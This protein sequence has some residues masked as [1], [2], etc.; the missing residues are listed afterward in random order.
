MP[1][2]GLYRVK[3]HARVRHYDPPPEPL[4]FDDAPR[5]DGARWA[6]PLG[7]FRTIT[8]SPTSVIAV[9]RSIDNY[10]TWRPKPTLTAPKGSGIIDWIKGTMVAAPDNPDEQLPVPGAVPTT[11]FEDATGLR[12]PHAGVPRF[13]DLDHRQTRE[14]LT[15]DGILERL[16]GIG[17]VTRPVVDSRDRRISRWT[18]RFLFELSKR[19]TDEFGAVVGVR[20]GDAYVVW[21]EQDL[22]DPESASSVCWPI[23]WSD[24]D[25]LEACRRLGLRVAPLG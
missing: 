11:Y 23:S 8:F 1:R 18:T 19:H 16:F 4:A 13:V 22:L 12:L 21:S 14:F 17:T 15:V 10:R 5:H 9:V 25:V 24:A 2:D 3:R 20:T 7:S 6:D